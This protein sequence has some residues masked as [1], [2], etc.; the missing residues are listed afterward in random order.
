MVI[1]PIYQDYRAITKLDQLC[2]L[3]P[4]VF[5]E[6]IEQTY[7]AHVA[8]VTGLEPP[9]TAGFLMWAK[10]TRALRERLRPA[11]WTHHNDKNLPVTISP[12]KSMVIVINSGDEDTGRRNGHPRTA[13]SKGSVTKAAI[14]RDQMKLFELEEIQRIVETGGQEFWVLLVH[15]D[16]GKEI[17]LELCRPTTH[18]E[19]NPITD[20]YERVIFD[21]ISLQEEVFTTVEPEAEV[22]IKT[23]RRIQ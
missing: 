17:R 8:P 7:Y 20:W 5:R 1:E 6:V 9:T 13:S 2:G 15:V 3:D 21:P 16:P 22:E 19:G 11:G 4:N 10:G 18:T 14:D 12:D 23:P